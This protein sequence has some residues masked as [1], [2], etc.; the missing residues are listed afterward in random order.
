MNTGS[1]TPE[2]TISGIYKLVTYPWFYE[3]FQNLLGAQKARARFFKEWVQTTDESAILELGCGPNTSLPFIRYRSY[4]GVD[5]NPKHIAQHHSKRSDVTHFHV[6][7]AQDI[8]PLL[9]QQFD[10]VLALGFLHHLNDASV[11]SLLDASIQKLS[12]TGCIYFLEPIYLSK[13]H[14]FAK[15]LKDKDSGQHIR[16]LGEY[17]ALLAR[18]GFGLDV[19]ISHDLLRVPYDH[20]WG[21]LSRR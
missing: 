11:A 3:A 18:D 16:S 19:K 13:Q 1:N 15:F 4:H 14:P 2:Q 17:E 7:A 12:P 20:F 9:E 10:V 21:R 5:I 6:G 8:V